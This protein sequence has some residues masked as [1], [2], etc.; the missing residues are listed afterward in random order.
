MNKFTNLM[1][2]FYNLDPNTLLI[3]GIILISIGILLLIIFIIIL[4]KDKETNKT[5]NSDTILENVIN[6]EIEKSENKEEK[7][8]IIIPTL[9][10]KEFDLPEDDIESIEIDNEINIKEE[11]EERNN[12]ENEETDETI[13]EVVIPTLPEKEFDIPEDDIESTDINNDNEKAEETNITEESLEKSI[14]V[15][16]IKEIA[17]DEKQKES[18]PRKKKKKKKKKKKNISMIN[19]DIPEEEPIA[20]PI[21]IKD[22]EIVSETLEPVSLED[23]KVDEIELE[24]VEEQSLEKEMEKETIEYEEIS[25]DM[26]EIV[27]KEIEVLSPTPIEPEI[28]V[29][30]KGKDKVV[31]LEDTEEIEFL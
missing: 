31:N 2:E 10:E 15:E 6:E 24:T 28:T 21:I 12:Q 14:L 4:A 29:P 30:L 8:E 7:D 16:E 11:P 27:K 23:K 19:S 17:D 5:N 26:P 22:N 9:P 20:T 1:N 3:S 13:K 25:D 18:E